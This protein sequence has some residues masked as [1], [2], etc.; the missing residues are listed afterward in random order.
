MARKDFDEYLTQVT[1]QYRSLQEALKEMSEEVENNMMSPEQL[2]QLKATIAPVKT[3][4]DTLN[5]I[6]YL[7]DKPKRKA[8]ESRYNK[9]NKRVLAASKGITKDEVIRKNDNILNSLNK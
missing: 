9:Q 5:Y 6:R 4:F 2:N 3:S 7:L 8:K 1:N